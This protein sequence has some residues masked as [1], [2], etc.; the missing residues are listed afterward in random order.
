[1]YTGVRSDGVFMAFDDVVCDVVIAIFQ[2]NVRFIIVIRVRKKAII[3]LCRTCAYVYN[4]YNTRTRRPYRYD[5]RS[6]AFV[7]GPTAAAPHAARRARSS[8]RY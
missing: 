1:M 2:G 7:V 4:L 3:T 6:I 5:I 8:D